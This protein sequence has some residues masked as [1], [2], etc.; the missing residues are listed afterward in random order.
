LNNIFDNEKNTPPNF[1]K[2]VLRTNSINL[3]V[4]WNFK[5]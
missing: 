1:E 4:S 2:K 5:I 3:I